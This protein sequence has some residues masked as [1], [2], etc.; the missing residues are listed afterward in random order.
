[1]GKFRLKMPVMPWTHMCVGGCVHILKLEV[2]D[3]GRTFMADR[4]Y[5]SPQD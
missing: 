4:G 5:L 2:S 1:M 3:E